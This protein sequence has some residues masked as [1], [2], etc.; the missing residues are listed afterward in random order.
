[1]KY[2]KTIAKEASITGIGL[3]TGTNTV[4][5]FKPAEANE[6]ITFVRNDLPGNP[7][8]PADI[9]YVVEPKDISRRTTLRKGDAEVETV[10]HVLAA[11]SALEIDNLTIELS[12]EEPPELDGSAAPF[13]EALKDAGVVEQKAA[14]KYFLLKEPVHYSCG[15]GVQLMAAPYDGFRI[16]FTIDYENS[17]IG[18]EYASYEINE[19]NFRKDICH[20][21]TFAFFK[22]VDMLQKSGLIKGGSLQN[23]IVVGE[24][25][26]INEEDLPYKT[27]SFVRHKILDLTGDL[28]LLGRPIKA[29]VTAIRSGHSSHV[30]F[31]KLLKKK[32]QKQI[33]NHVF[34]IR[35]IE[36]IMP[37]RYP[38][39]LVDRI[40]EMEESKSVVGIKNVTRN[41]PFFN[42]HFPDYPIMPGVLIIEA[43]AQ[44]GGVLLLN[45]VDNPDKYLVYFMKIDKAKFRKPVIPGDQLVF[46]LK[47]KKFK[48]KTCI[49]SGEAFVDDEL[50]AEAELTSMIVEKGD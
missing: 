43:M 8:I 19:E 3:H 22:D 21:K 29:H 25:S 11:L 4:I 26:V 50:V 2:Q 42:G 13:F 9:D 5:T 20:S 14:K 7:R 40:L 35:A 32:M 15:N 30:K 39:L 34:G 31:V 6:G 17:F 45:S 49:M 24:D 12:A 36:K 47:M 28:V 10:E 44:T 37:H 33:H 48:H 23:A 1:M 46:K 16:S 18:T 38:F 41:E 27:N